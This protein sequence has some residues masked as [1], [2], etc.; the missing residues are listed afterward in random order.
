M[1]CKDVLITFLK[2]ARK[3]RD[4]SQHEF[5]ELLAIPFSTY[6]GYEYGQASLGPD[7]L[8]KISERLGVSF[9]EMFTIPGEEIK[10]RPKTAI[11]VLA[12]HL[13][14]EIKIQPSLNNYFDS[15]LA[16][17]ISSLGEKE[18]GLIERTVDKMLDTP[19]QK[20]KAN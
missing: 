8:D 12:R 7:V 1:N 14:Y 19:A 18:L 4:M 10:I 11:E 3:E 13:G 9:T 5:S 20:K 6:K 16:L 15:E 17:K 2:R